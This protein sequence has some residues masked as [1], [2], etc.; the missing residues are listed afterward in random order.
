VEAAEG[1][2]GTTNSASNGPGARSSSRGSSR[3][4]KDGA[5][6]LVGSVGMGDGSKHAQNM[7][8]KAYSAR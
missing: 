2:A 4:G 6:G 8:Y 1:E 3:V 7:C 5:A